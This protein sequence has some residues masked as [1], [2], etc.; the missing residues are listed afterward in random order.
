MTTVEMVEY[1]G[2]EDCV[3]IAN[4]TVEVVATTA[5]GPRIVGLGYLDGENLCYLADD[6]GTSPDDGEWHLFGGHRLWHAPE[7]E[8]R[9]ARPDNDPVGVERHEDGVTLSQPAEGQTHVAKA[10]TI[11]LPSSGA[12]VAVTHELTNEGVWAVELAPWAITVLRPGGQAVLP[13]TPDGQTGRQADR[14]L[15]FWSYTDPDDDRLSYREDCILLAQAEAEPT[16]VGVE[17][18]DGW[19]A[20]VVDGTALLKSFTRRSGAH[21]ADRGAALQA[22]TDDAMLELETLGPLE[23]VEPGAT[24]THEE[25]WRLLADVE[26]GVNPVATIEAALP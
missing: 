21:Y 11:R 6:A 19:G 5:V 14:S 4:G 2:W 1:A 22:Y 15:V 3:R 9:T 8:G 23:T 24:A 20:Y 17:G 13:M 25:W 26:V 16:K 10:L 12:E 18:R 7:V